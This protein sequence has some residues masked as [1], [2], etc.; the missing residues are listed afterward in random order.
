MWDCITYLNI[1]Y[2]TYN[3]KYINNHKSSLAKNYLS[4]QQNKK[5]IKWLTK[6]Q[7]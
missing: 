2:T 1:I 3:I 6:N 5:D 4:H 7:Y